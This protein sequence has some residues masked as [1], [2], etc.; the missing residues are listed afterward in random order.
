MHEANEIID[1]IYTAAVDPAA[2]REA[3]HAIR[4]HYGAISAGLYE[5][6]LQSGTVQLVHLEGIDP[7]EIAP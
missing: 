5:A 6:D 7:G 1:R 4:V 3:V 2:W